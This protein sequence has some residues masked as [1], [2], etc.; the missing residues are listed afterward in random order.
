MGGKLSVG[1]RGAEGLN[2][3]P[4]KKKKRKTNDTP[5]CFCFWEKKNSTQGKPALFT[6]KVTFSC[7][8]ELPCSAI[9]RAGG[10]NQ[11]LQCVLYR[12]DCVHP[13]VQAPLEE[14][15]HQRP[16]VATASPSR[17]VLK[18]PKK[19]TLMS[20][21]N[22]YVRCYLVFAFISAPRLLPWSTNQTFPPNT[23]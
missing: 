7:K 19:G 6:N 10:G 18:T 8:V 11:R 14:K 2:A 12:D 13:V 15:N 1:W 16:L 3:A 21:M 23:D 17:V 22:H 20:L 9:L 5:A 4:L